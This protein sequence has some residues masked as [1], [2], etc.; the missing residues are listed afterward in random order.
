MEEG[1]GM[2]YRLSMEFKLFFLFLSDLT[3]RVLSYSLIDYDIF[4][5]QNGIKIYSLIYIIY[6]K[7]Y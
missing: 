7:Y 6:Q 2:N 3:L 5:M 1:G 4:L